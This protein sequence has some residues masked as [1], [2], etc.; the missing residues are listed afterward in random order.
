MLLLLGCIGCGN[1]MET[2]PVAEVKGKVLCNGQPVPEV[3]VFFDPLKPK[4]AGGKDT[5]HVGKLGMGISDKDGVFRISTY[6]DGDG[7]VVG[8]H[9]IRVGR[10]QKFDSSCP[11]EIDKS[12]TLKEVEVKEGMSNDFEIALRPEGLQTKP[13]VSD[14]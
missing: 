2:F 11:C 1:G 12:F 5:T 7:A 4:G 13:V 3:V 10:P 9:R 6:G 8:P 14:D